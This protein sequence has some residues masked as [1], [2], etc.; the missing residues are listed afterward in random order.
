MRL[1]LI[2]AARSM[3]ILAMLS[4]GVLV[5]AAMSIYPGGTAWDHATRGHDFWLNYLCDLERGVALNGEPNPLGSALA[6]TAMS[7][8][9]AGLL[10]FFW[11]V[12]TLF[13]SRPRLGR[14]VR[15]L[16][17]V[18]VVAI[19]VVVFLPADR[20][21]GIHGVAVV[22]AGI[23]GLAAGI[24]AVIGL[25]A[26]RGAPRAARAIG[27]AALAVATVD[28]GLFL[29]EVLT[30]AA[31]HV[32]VAVLE[33]VS[34]F[35]VLAWMFVVARHAHR[36]AKA[37]AGVVGASSIGDDAS[38]RWQ[39]ASRGGTPANRAPEQALLDDPD[40]R[41]RGRHHARKRRVR[42]GGD[43]R[44]HEL[45]RDERAHGDM[46]GARSAPAGADL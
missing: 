21:A 43:P 30:P 13:P 2:L 4:F 41:A 8:L 3:V 37:G 44:E 7:A 27:L 20:F 23:P 17:V 38:E 5:V 6:R 40:V 28:F 18:T 15:V 33:R 19:E 1:R 24:L 34:T 35:L 29:P 22:A 9:A 46:D 39:Y 16:G 31:S 10:P 14:C 36:L 25:V 12:S 26:E 11:L 32:A 42:D 45:H